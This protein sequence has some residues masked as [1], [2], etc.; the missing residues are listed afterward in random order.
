MTESKWT[1]A[2]MILAWALSVLIEI[3]SLCWICE[4]CP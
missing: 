1:D 3:G 4:G 2:D